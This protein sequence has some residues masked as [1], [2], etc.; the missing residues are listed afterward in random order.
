[1]KSDP[2]IEQLQQQIAALA[3]DANQLEHQR[4]YNAEL[5]RE[6]DQQIADEH[7]G[8]VVAEEQF[9]MMTENAKS[10]QIARQKAEQQIAD[11]QNEL[12]VLDKSV[13]PDGRNGI[14][15]LDRVQQLVERHQHDMEAVEGW[16]VEVAT[17]YER[18]AVLEAREEALREAWS[19]AR[20]LGLTVA[21]YDRLNQRYE[22]PVV[23][24][25]DLDALLAPSSLGGE[26]PVGRRE[27]PER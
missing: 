3:R 4:E 16:R 26:T 10:L 17:L 9:R 19:K 8:R 24:V 18:L 11:L 27:E 7:N 2:T 5:V 12:E 14:D 23:L 6:R 15:L 13:P 1:V 20:L 21:L 25:R 22:V